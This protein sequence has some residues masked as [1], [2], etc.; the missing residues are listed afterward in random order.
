MKK[1]AV[2]ALSL[3]LVLSLSQAKT[4]AATQ[5][6][7]SPKRSVLK[8]PTRTKSVLARAVP[9]YK[10]QVLATNLGINDND[11]PAGSDELD[12]QSPYRRPELVQDVD[13][14]SDLSD[15]V[16]T[17]LLIARLRALKKYQDAWA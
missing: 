7:E 16:R 1:L 13:T 9:K 8:N 12:L 14:D 4:M 10:R 5:A 2:T 11:D 15:Y 3:F 17:R 6:Q